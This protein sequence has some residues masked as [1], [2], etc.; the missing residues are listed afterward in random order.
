MNSF[1]KAF[2]FATAA[3]A[4]LTFTSS[5]SADSHASADNKRAAYS[6]DVRQSV[7]TLLGNNMGP[8]GA[9]AR[10]KMPFDAALAE[11]SAIR[12]SQLS[13]MITDSFAFNTTEYDLL[14]TDALDVIWDKLD[15][16]EE[17]A[18]ALTEAANV[19]ASTAASGDESATKKAI[20]GVGKTCGSCHDDFKVDDD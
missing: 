3:S 14:E 1:S 11:K 12:I 19:L 13:E 2:I 8:L 15:S 10:G 9:M 16:F 20:G 7:F 6:V 17:K 5:V 18:A 4:V